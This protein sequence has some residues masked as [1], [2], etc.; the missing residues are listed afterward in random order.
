MDCR[1]DRQQGG[2]QSCG[3]AVPVSLVG[4]ASSA[5]PGSPQTHLTAIMETYA[6]RLARERFYDTSSVDRDDPQTMQ[7]KVRVR[8]DPA[9]RRPID[10]L[11]LPR[12]PLAQVEFV[13]QPE[14]PA[15]VFT[16][17]R[18]HFGTPQDRDIDVVIRATCRIEVDGS[19]LCGKAEWTEPADGPLDPGLREL[20][21]RTAAG[22]YQTAAK[23]RDG[24]PSAGRVIELD[25][26][27][28]NF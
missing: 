17:V 3:P 19:L 13:H 11:S 23:L 14:Q 7:G 6:Q 5:G 8:L 21:Y 1:I 24:S 9:D 26:H 10:F 22:R 20:A 16:L 25:L 27:F 2:V 28:R 15:P 12:T 18:Q 4:S